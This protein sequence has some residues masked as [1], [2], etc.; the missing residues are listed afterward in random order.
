M[1]DYLGAA[2]AERK[3]E[4]PY[5]SL[6][7]ERNPFPGTPVPEDEPNFLFARESIGDDIAKRTVR[8]ILEH[9][10]QHFVV[11]GQYGSGKSHLLKYFKHVIN[12]RFLPEG[13][14]VA[15]Y[16]NHPGKNFQEFYRNLV[17]G[18]S[19]DFF[20]SLYRKYIDLE[21][22]GA[23][24]QG[25][26]QLLNVLKSVAADTDSRFTAWQWLQGSRQGRFDLEKLGIGYSNHDVDRQP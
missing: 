2:I 4:L 23:T 8:A 22:R 17:E 3:K 12:A 18:L 7:L 11:L 21:P 26:P 14:A 19:L 20:G 25:T 24:N 13:R 16:I 9:D 6:G 1:K 15:A 10:P 5:K